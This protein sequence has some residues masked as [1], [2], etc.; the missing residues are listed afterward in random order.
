MS[1]AHDDPE[2]TAAEYVLGT[3]DPEEAC[4]AAGRAATE[5]GLAQAIA[6]WEDRLGPL[7]ALV[8]P[9]APPA[10]LWDRIAASLAAPGSAPRI[11]VLQTL[12]FWRAATATGFA[13]AAALAAIAFLR[14]PSPAAVAALIPPNGTPAAFLA[15]LQ[16]NGAIRLIPLEPVQVASGRALELWALPP[17]KAHPVPLG[18]LPPSGRKLPAPM[19]SGNGTQLMVSLEPSGGSQVGTPSGPVLWQGTLRS[20]L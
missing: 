4:A 11:P 3:L 16:R 7:A 17:G 15:E 12:W 18:L 5:P 14:Q 19:R 8:E 2:L 13:L 6:R 1:G 9:V 20:G 10:T